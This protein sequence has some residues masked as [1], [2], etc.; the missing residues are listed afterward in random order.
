VNLGIGLREVYIGAGFFYF[1]RVSK[2]ARA[3]LINATLITADVSLMAVCTIDSA[4]RN[5]LNAAVYLKKDTLGVD[6]VRF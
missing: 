6:F 5:G 3:G 1:A 4:W 2:F